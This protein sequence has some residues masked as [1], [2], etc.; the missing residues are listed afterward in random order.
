MTA[1]KLKPKAKIG[2]DQIASWGEM[3]RNISHVLESGMQ[4]AGRAA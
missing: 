3:G 4:I 1:K 2:K